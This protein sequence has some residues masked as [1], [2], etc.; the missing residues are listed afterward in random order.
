MSRSNSISTSAIPSSTLVSGINQK[1]STTT[2]S[3]FSISHPPLPTRISSLI[4]TLLTYLSRDFI[5][6]WYLPLSSYPAPP[7]KIAHFIATSTMALANRTRSIDIS[8]LIITNFLP[9]ITTHL[10]D[11]RRAE[12]AARS[13]KLVKHVIGA[14][15][16]TGLYH[17]G[18]LHPAVS[19][20]TTSSSSSSSSSSFSSLGMKRN[21]FSPSSQHQNQS[22]PHPQ[23]QQQSRHHHLHQECIGFGE[24]EK[25]YLRRLIT[26]IV[27]TILNDGDSNTRS[28]WDN[29]L[30]RL[31][32]R[33]ILVC[34]VLGPLMA[35]ISDPDWWNQVIVQWADTL[36]PNADFLEKPLKSNDI[37]SFSFEK[38]ALSPMSDSSSPI[39]HTHHARSYSDFISLIRDSENL[40]TTRSLRDAIT[41]ELSRRSVEIS[42]LSDSDVVNGRKVGDIKMY[43]NKLR[44]AKRRVE[45]R[46]VSLG[47]NKVKKKKKNRIFF[48]LN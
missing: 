40:L 3:A 45:K 4:S 12:R 7:S 23:Q 2:K 33:E 1:P 47:Y 6:P 21:S 42:G 38:K 28:E 25:C 22:Q 34:K 18:K 20:P 46:L 37:S 9:K 27:P 16:V 39:T 43:V 10:H 13:G 32:I 11:Y 8:Q 26:G 5:L 15:D 35:T 19:T 24:L 30:V 44:V 48:Y 17:N 14:S 29:K 31:L 36:I 41:T